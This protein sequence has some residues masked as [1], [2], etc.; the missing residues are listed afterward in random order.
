[1]EL[2]VVHGAPCCCLNSLK[3]RLFVVFSKTAVRT[4]FFA[5]NAKNT[6]TRM[7]PPRGGWSARMGDQNAYSRPDPP[8]L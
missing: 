5:K 1:M 7:P 2:E 6:K 4:A 3:K 8:P